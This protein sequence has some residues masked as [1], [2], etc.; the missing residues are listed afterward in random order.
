MAMNQKHMKKIRWLLLLTLAALPLFFLPSFFTNLKLEALL[1]KNTIENCLTFT[2][3]GGRTLKCYNG[4]PD[5]PDS[6]SYVF[7][8]SFADMAQIGVETIADRVDFTG[9]AE[10]GTITVHAGEPASCSFETGVPYRTSFR[11]STGK[12]IGS[13]TIIFLK[14]GKLPTMYVT[15]ETGSMDKLDADKTY[16]EKGAFEF[17]D[18]EGNPVFTGDLR[19]IS[20]RGNQ[21]FTFEKKSYQINLKI[22]VDFMGM[23]TSDTWILLSNVYDPAYIRNRLTYEMAL[24]AGMAGSPKSEYVDVY[25]NGAYAGMYQLCEKVE[26][27][28]NRLEIANLEMQNRA[29]N[30]EKLDY[31]DTFILEDGKGKGT[32]LVKNPPDITGGYLIEH[33]YGEKYD[34]VT[35]GFRTDA[36]ECFTLKN[37]SHAS[38]EEISYIRGIMQEI[39]DAIQTED[40]Y[41]PVTGRHYTEYIDLESW[42]DK[43]LVEEIT[44]NNGGGSTSSYFYKPQDTIST[45]VYGGPV[46]DYDKGYG[47]AYGYN[48]NTRDLAFLTLHAVYTNWFYYLYGHEDFVEAVKKEYRE[49]FADYLTEMAE[50]K[51]DEYLL[52]IAESAVLDRAR[53]SHVYRSFGEDAPDYMAQ[54]QEVKQ[55]ILERK[56]FL[57]EVWLEDAEICIVHFKDENGDGNRSIGVKKG[58]CIQAFPS[59]EWETREFLGWKMEGTEEY[60]TLQTPI[61]EELTVYAT[62]KT[63]G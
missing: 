1:R 45:K 27:G 11:N 48:Q 60:L 61:T 33:D 13:E 6:I 24:Q 4:N 54:A 25:F 46:W 39:E 15:T 16:K 52:A 21:T 37:P 9:G 35:S 31:A 28:E 50:G 44:R 23:G 29:L 56:A 26:I 5:H 63:D 42:A 58:E 7:L 18:T 34:E 10:N 36:G 55:F 30:G 19:S 12:E 62:W 2:Y 32:V 41:H 53:F 51:A 14:S 3:G 47:N 49:K 20:G 40:G 22:P 8:P 43:Y 38:P 17:L 59:D 57:D